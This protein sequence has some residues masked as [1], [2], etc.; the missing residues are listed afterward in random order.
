MPSVEVRK[1]MNFWNLVY[2][3]KCGL[4]LAN[5][6]LR[7]LQTFL[8]PGS[9]FK[10]IFPVEN[11]FEK[12]T[13]RSGWQNSGACSK[14]NCKHLGIDLCVWWPF[15]FKFAGC[16]F[17]QCL[18]KFRRVPMDL[19]Q[20]PTLS[21]EQLIA[22][23]L[24]II[25]ELS[26]RCGVQFQVTADIGTPSGDAPSSSEAAP[27]ATGGEAPATTGGEPSTSSVT[28]P[29]EGGDPL[30]ATAAVPSPSTPT[31]PRDRCCYLCS[32]RDCQSW[33]SA[34]GVHR[35]HVCDYHSWY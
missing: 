16:V 23:A 27:A 5:L 2:K 34:T 11:L 32:V 13:S 28:V 25:C 20:V 6:L 21:N 17:C 31:A 3:V 26:R 12:Q 35:Q 8:L 10:N 19:N 22:W 18:A 29:S 9:T 24:A 1:R 15:G 4:Q 7:F 14:L 30:T 33:C